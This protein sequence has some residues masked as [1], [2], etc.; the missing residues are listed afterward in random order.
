[1]RNF[2]LLRGL[3]GFVLLFT[4]AV[5]TASDAPKLTFKFTTV[6]VPGAVQTFPGGVNNAGVM[7]G[8]Y[9]DQSQVAHGYIRSGKKLT[10]VDHPQSVGT[11]CT[12][13]PLNGTIAV[14]G[15]YIT[16]LGNSVG[17][18]YKNGTFTDIPGPA[19]AT[20]SAAFGINDTEAIVGD[21]TDS[22]GATHGFM[23]KGTT[24]TTL[25]VPGGLST[26][27]YGIDNKGNIL[28]SWEDSKFTF[29]ASLYNGKTYKAI[30]VPGAAHSIAYDLNSA[31]DV[32]Y[33]WFDASGTSHGALLVAGKYYKFAYPKALFTY[34]SG[35]NDKSTIVGVYETNT[36]G[37]SSG[38]KATFK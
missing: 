38:F 33:Q 24:Y 15:F 13:L 25:D 6:N 22:S 4:V 23:L 27:A 29:K 37:P 20:A 5:A 28:L 16:T 1:M 32:V 14:V 10:P 34:G 3:S 18:L 17:F 26:V 19:G 2:K 8:E 12:N 35:I 36:S 31:G 21:Y 9:I 30:N 11:S 7:V